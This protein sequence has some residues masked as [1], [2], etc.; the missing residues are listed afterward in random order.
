ML[1]Y[2]KTCRGLSLIELIVTMIILGILAGGVVPVVRMTAQR[3][4]EVELRRNLRTIR[5][6]ID[7]FHKECKKTPA[8]L[9]RPEACSTNN[10]PK[11][12]KILKDGAKFGR[13]ATNEEIK[14]LRREIYDPFI[15]LENRNNDK[16]GWELR[17]SSYKPDDLKWDDVD[18]FDVYAVNGG[19]SLDGTKYEEW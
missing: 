8:N 9:P 4:K 14:F 7:E 16:W 12:L 3:S 18:V 19:I 15:S 5:A 6:A 11:T 1:R 17:S 13:T 2:L 10:Y